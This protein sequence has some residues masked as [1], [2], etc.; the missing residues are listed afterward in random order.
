[1]TMN[2]F[3]GQVVQQFDQNV[4]G[5]IQILLKFGENNMY[6]FKEVQ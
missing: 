4:D 3:D 5:V 1:M 6:I 2:H